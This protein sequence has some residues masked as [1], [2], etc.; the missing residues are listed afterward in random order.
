MTRVWSL[1]AAWL[2]SAVV[3]TIWPQVDLAV[4]GIFYDP[5]SAAWLGNAPLAEAL[6][7]ALWRMTEAAAL[8]FLVLLVISLLR[9]KSAATPVRASVFALLTFA[10]AP[11]II[12][13]GLLKAHW[14]RA[15]PRT[16]TEF[17]GTSDFTPALEIS[18][19]CARNCSFVAGEVAGVVAVAMVLWLLFSGRLAPAGRVTFAALLLSLS[20]ASAFLRVSAG[21]HF[22]SDSVFAALIS[23]TVALLLWRWLGVERV[24]D[25]LTFANIA[26]DLRNLIRRTPVQK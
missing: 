9:R 11:G 25:R 24:A 10:M 12:V 6:R 2:L 3:F 13:N 16:V 21:G 17:G 5:V 19:Q 18:D 8:V 7:S 22:L 26:N 1:V 4:S 20:L 14:G 23:V 15:R